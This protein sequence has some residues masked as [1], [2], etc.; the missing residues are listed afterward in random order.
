MMFKQGGT[1]SLL[2]LSELTLFS[3]IYQ[4]I[5]LDYNECDIL[6]DPKYFLL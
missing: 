5:L 1:E 2:V 4:I 3:I 6:F